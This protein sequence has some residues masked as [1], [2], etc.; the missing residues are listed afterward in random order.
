MLAMQN[1]EMNP[2]EI[3][4]LKLSPDEYE[5]GT[6]KFDLTLTVEEEADCFAFTMTYS[7]ALFNKST[8]KRFID[9]FN[10]ILTAIAAD[11]HQPLGGIDILADEEKK[12]LL[13]GFNLTQQSYPG[14]KTIHR[15]FEEQVEQ[16][17]DHIAL[18][19]KVGEW[20]DRSME[21]K[22]EEGHLSYRELNER[23][24]Q[25]GQLL[26]K[27]GVK[28]ETITGIMMDPSPEMI[29]GILAVLKAG[30]AYLPIGPQQQAGRITYMLKD[31]RAVLLLTREHAAN[32]HAFGV[33]SLAI[34]RA[35]VYKGKGN[36]PGRKS[37]PADV[38]YTI[39]TS[40][41]TGK[42]KGTLIENRNLV[43]YVCWF[44]G[45][46]HLTGRDRTVLTSSFS[47]DLGYT[48]I[49]SS[50]LTGCQLHIIPA[51]TY[52]SP[53]DLIGYIDQHG[54]TYI[55]VTPSLFTTIVENSRFSQTACPGLRLVVLGGE[56]IKLKDVEKAHRIA[57]HLHFMNH[58]GPTEAT[59]GCVARFIDFNRFDDFKKRP[60]IGTPIDNMK[61]FIMDN[62]LMMV[63]VG[64]PGELCVAG[65]NVARGYLNQPELTAE[66][67]LHVSNSSNMS[68]MTYIIYKTGDMARWTS[69]G[70]V[71]FL[72]RIDTQVK[73]RGYRIEPGEIENR[74]LTH[75][76]VNEAVV[77]PRE[78][79]FGDKY[80]C[81]YVTLKNPGSINIPAL[82]EYLAVE[83]PDY[84]IP[85]FFVELERIPLTPNGKLNRKLLPEPGTADLRTPYAAPRDQVEE[86]LVQLWQEILGIEKTGINDN[87]FEI[88]GHSL[89]AIMLIAR[90]NKAFN[91]K[92]KLPELFK[93]PT[94]HQLSQHIKQGKEEEFI[95]IEAVEEKEYYQLSSSQNQIYILQQMDESNTVY[96]MPSVWL[97]EGALDREKLEEVLSTLI[98]RHES[99]RTSLGMIGEEP[100]QRIHKHVEFEIEC[101][102]PGLGTYA[103][104]IKNFIRPFDLSHAPLLR[105]GL[106]KI[107]EE[108]HLL[109]ID[110][111]HT[112]SD[113]VSL[114][115]LIKDLMVIYAGEDL[116]L[117]MFRYRDYA[118][119]QDH[120]KESKDLKKQEEFWITRL[121]GEIPTIELPIDYT[122]PRQQGFAGSR[123]CFDITTGETRGLKET[124]LKTGGTWYMIL[125]TIYNILLS[126]L[127]SQ[128]DIIVGAPT[129]N[130]QHADLE[131]ITGMFVN[132]LCLRHFPRGEK[133]VS[134]FLQ[135]VKQETLIV[136]ENQDYPF[137]DLVEKLAIRRDTGRNPLFDVVLILHDREIPRIEIPGLV[138]T[139][140]HYQNP[141]T[142]F[143]L[144]LHAEETGEYLSFTF[145]Y[146]T[147]LFKETTIRR[148]AGYFKNLVNAVLTGTEK[149]I[150]E[151]ELLSKEEK[152][153]LLY[154]FNPGEAEYPTGKTINELFASQVEKTPDGIAVEMHNTNGRAGEHSA[155]TYR[156]LNK[157]SLQLACLLR[158]KGVDGSTIVALKVERSLEMILGI[159]GILKQGGSYVPLDPKAPAART[160]YIMADCH[161][162]LLLT[163]S[164][165]SEASKA[166]GGL[167]VVD[168]SVPVFA[169]SLAYVIYTS[170]S[171][172]K[173]KGVPITHSNLSPLLHWGY[174]H[175]GLSFGERTL[176]NLSYFFDWSVWEIFITLTT[177]A[178][179]FI[180]PDE[181]LLDPQAQADFIDKNAIT[182]LHITPTQ[183]RYL[184]NLH[185]RLQT[186]RYLF[187]GAEKLS[188]ELV[189]CSI[190]S[191]SD[192]CR[193]FNM[194]G[195]T[196]ATI[197]SAVLE[198]DKLTVHRYSQLPSIPIGKPSGNTKLL[199]LDRHRKIC[200]LNVA[201]E[202]YISGAAVAKGYLNNPELTFEKFDHDLWDCYDGYHRS[203][204]SYKSYITHRSYLYRTGDLAKWLPDET[205]IF[206]GRI[207]HQVKVRGYRIELGEIENQLLK[208]PDI[209]ETVVVAKGEN[210][211][212][213]HL[214]AYLVSE[215]QLP[216][217]RLRNHLSQY[218][219]GYMIPS[220]FMQIP[221]IPFNPNGKVDL[222]ALPE[223]KTSIGEG[224]AY[225]PPCDEIEKKLVKIWSDILEY[226]EDRIGRNTNFFEIGG[227]SLKA[228]VLV[229]KIHRELNVKLP[230]VELFTRPTLKE[231]ARFTREAGENKS[232]TIKP[233]AQKD[234]YVLSSAQ[235]RL[236]VL[237]QMTEQSTVYNMPAVMML[238]GTTDKDR[239][240]NTFR[241]LIQRHENLRTSFANINDEPVQ[242]VHDNVELE[243]E[244]SDMKAVEVKVDD[245]EGTGGLAPLTKES[246][247]SSVIRHL[248]SE[249]IRPFDLYLAPL[250]RVGLIKIEEKQHLL[251]VDMHHIITDGVSAG[252][253]VKE[254]VLLYE[255]K[256][257]APLKIQYKDFA[258]W[259]NKEKEKAKT[260][261]D[262]WLSRFSGDIARLDLPLDF[263]RPTVPTY[264]GAEISVEI[265]RE[266]TEKI[267]EMVSATGAT[268]HMVLLAVYN[269]LLSKYAGREDIIIGTPVA[270]RMHPDIQNII[271]MFVNVLALRNYPA[272]NK[273]FS[274]FLQ[275]VKQDTLE[276]YENQAYQ[277]EDLVNRL[278]LHREVNRH[279]LFDV[280]FQTH[281]VEEG[282]SLNRLLAAE[283]KLKVTPCDFKNK[284]TKYDLVHE[285][286]LKQDKILLVQEYSTVLWKK[287]TIEK[288]VKRYL[289]I[290]EQVLENNHI[291]L[292]DISISI[293]L[294]AAKSSV[295]QGDFN[296]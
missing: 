62:G 100:V 8:I 171:T 170:G 29:I 183:Y 40:G 31:S 199:V 208:H 236:Y 249:F 32:A 138:V 167:G 285:A 247:L 214:C 223:P 281:I 109:M 160:Q 217:A 71:E 156:E 49:Y 117:L 65:A 263:P 244:F 58:Y 38:V 291:R 9:Y 21:V 70:T 207:D 113:G 151:I 197:I 17:P 181:V 177:G 27:E 233:A 190:Q 134:Q 218:L 139:P 69:R 256:S 262:Y 128:E 92:V 295:I 118:K 200:P 50:I 61:A 75:E 168:V 198:I 169:D 210:N 292:K 155:L 96:N 288:F 224:E 28:R 255:G 266:L 279:P 112:I 4:G 83:L 205:V 25:L 201:G 180:V 3:P 19:G 136:L 232:V 81:A 216:A 254:F 39:Y 166:I 277:F 235:K 252:I 248:S 270:G 239:L 204:R 184:A 33:P 13:Y 152:N 245:Y 45:K 124:A 119:W 290:L 41:T 5:P 47:F 203:N 226:E 269:I 175:L 79:P 55:K 74:L 192:I 150:S 98:K 196:E 179:L 146:S 227:H 165:L 173:P 157:K 274:Q 238:E 209:K 63:P 42:S 220:Y 2:I 20:K 116:P 56:E 284:K 36:N 101:Y 174:R 72:G 123:W 10:R 147:K 264:D 44:K 176:Q 115:V 66:K 172:G 261:A 22:R 1:M 11:L 202:L 267:K 257:L 149:K 102:G 251:M 260:Q 99:L 67:F 135:E 127:S 273:T 104:T 93:A 221:R 129:A 193:V 18:V 14:N 182:V 225:I 48:A 154:D 59:I 250:L 237:H 68:Y 85:S 296:F 108:K 23:A 278:G 64:V 243:I 15:I 195:P 162:N 7:T 289:D 137:E 131:Q 140:R 211:G 76:A 26:R 163:G 294:P 286:F 142:K 90:I 242:V 106:I 283:N 126:K 161:I 57:G 265:N 231:L 43:N 6:S 275:E 158:Q 30:G 35:A 222:R 246:H 130:R 253:M 34:A 148:F 213:S 60:T 230:L 188:Y 105:V 259:E 88:G 125:V 77:I 87:F 187:I 103:S 228:T 229:L 280:V 80:L 240:E 122:R 107:E 94:I 191:V 133:S 78:H 219:P 84:M 276:A 110:M 282:E 145:E 153:R 16:T 121:S 111:H 144:I 186:L 185:H 189:K 132:T 287:N 268:V 51:L 91:V 114:Y 24:N 52:Q 258:E 82:K 53:E 272:E 159:L 54:I 234:Y 37:S 194:Y 215:K 178:S 143:D 141:T 97:L 86:K 95:S 271:G 206:L 73:I 293:D 241:R 120:R 46:V 89:K 212:D 12:Q 164:W